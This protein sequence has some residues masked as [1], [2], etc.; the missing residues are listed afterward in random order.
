[1]G[2]PDYSRG[3]Y[4]P[5]QFGDMNM[6][7]IVA[8]IAGG[9]GAVTRVAAESS[10]ETTITRDSAGQYS[11][12]FPKCQTAFPLRPVLLLAEGVG[13]DMYWEALSATSGTGTLEAAVNTAAATAAD[14][15]D[16]T[17]IYI[18]LLCGQN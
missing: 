17:K 15:A 10:P 12:T 9:S 16:A 7:V 8:T 6:V 14:P 1:M 18:A 2:F 13:S 4:K 3:F 11:I 5:K